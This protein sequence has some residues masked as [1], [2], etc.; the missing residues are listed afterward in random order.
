MISGRLGLGRSGAAR[1]P[2]SPVSR[3]RRSLFATGVATMHERAHRHAS[4]TAGAPASATGA[5]PP[6]ESAPEATIYTCPMHPQIRQPGPGNCP[7]CGMSL[8][9]VLPTLDEGPD[10]ELVSFQ[11]RFWWTLP[12]TIV[13]TALGMAG[14]YLTGLS[15][16]ARTW[17]E[18]ALSAPIVLWAGWPFFV[19]CA[20]SIRRRHPNMWTLIGVGVG[21]AFAYSLAATLVPDLFP[22][23]FESH[24][25][26]GVYYEAAAVIVSL[27][28]LG[29]ILE[30]KARA[31]T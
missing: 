27:T 22:Q 15:V 9:P 21:A 26:I 13:V 4:H 24:G 23:G 12:L 8:E 19:R 30:M 3:N 10:P 18:L 16:A 11:H 2:L 28:L 17:L 31:R 6:S 7:I 29:Q 1:A 5:T 20:E 14:H 25:R